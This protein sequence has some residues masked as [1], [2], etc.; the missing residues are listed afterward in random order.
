MSCDTAWDWEGE[1]NQGEPVD[2]PVSVS[3]CPVLLSLILM[4][5]GIVI[6]SVHR[7]VAGWRKTRVKA[8]EKQGARGAQAGQ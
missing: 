4:N 6:D 1:V 2:H 8:R 5:S 7:C 3:A